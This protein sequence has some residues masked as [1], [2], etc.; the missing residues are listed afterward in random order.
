MDTDL[1]T[2]IIFSFEKR[3]FGEHVFAKKYPNT[4]NE[5]TLRGFVICHVHVKKESRRYQMGGI[6]NYTLMTKSRSLKY[7]VQNNDTL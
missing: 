1:I 4:V 6:I 5:M 2:E 3:V 7:N